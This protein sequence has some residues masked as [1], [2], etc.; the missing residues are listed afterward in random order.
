MTIDVWTKCDGTWKRTLSDIADDGWKDT[1]MTK[2]NF[3]VKFEFNKVRVAGGK[4]V[5]LSKNGS[6]EQPIGLTR[7]AYDTQTDAY[8]I[9]NNKFIQV[10]I[11][12]HTLTAK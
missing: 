2:N 9:E 1:V 4:L 6:I 8:L 10:F 11:Y 7:S 3:P 5:S 12:S